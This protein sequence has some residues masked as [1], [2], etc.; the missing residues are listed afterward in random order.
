MRSVK[1]VAIKEPWASQVAEGRD[2][3]AYRGAK[4][5]YRG[6]ILIVSDAEPSYALALAEL[7]DVRPLTGEANAP[8]RRGFVWHFRGVVPI[9]RFPLK[10][11]AGLF[12]A[13]IPE[14][15]LPD[16][17]RSVL[18]TSPPAAAGPPE[19][20]EQDRADAVPASGDL[21]DTGSGRVRGGRSNDEAL[22]SSVAGEVRNARASLRR[23]AADL[24][25]LASRPRAAV[26]P[27]LG[28]MYRA[29]EQ[30]Q[31]G[32]DRLVQEMVDGDAAWRQAFAPW[33]ADRD[34]GVVGVVKVEPGSPPRLPRLDLLLVDDEP[35]FAR[36]F[37]R[38]LSQAHSVRIA[39]SK[40]EALEELQRK[41]PNVLVCDYQVDWQSTEDL[42]QY[43]KDNYPSVRRVLYSFSRIEIWCDLLHRKLV[44]AAVPKS[45]PRGQLLD[46]LA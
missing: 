43:V 12:M 25:D 22:K 10:A 6:E 11:Q 2:T 26:G 38:S 40:K 29:V 7:A 9:V 42:L 39:H 32:V 36:G 14:G 1:A 23:I 34:A 21:A 33:M 20:S 37:Q 35:R 18:P 13:S 44:H 31:Q 5:S 17:W 24:Q 41:V 46:A 27:Q 30:L 28:A 45:A 4:T 19:P 8:I 16:G 3:I 15:A